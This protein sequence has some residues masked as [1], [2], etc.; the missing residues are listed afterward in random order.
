MQTLTN[1][2]ND[3]TLILCTLQNKHSYNRINIDIRQG[4]LNNKYY[5]YVIST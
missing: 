2:I 5:V 3:N 4:N 1:N